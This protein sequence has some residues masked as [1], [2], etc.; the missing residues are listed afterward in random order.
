VDLAGNDLA[1]DPVFLLAADSAAPSDP[2]VSGGSTS[3]QDASSVTV[4]ASGSTDTG[5]SDGVSGYQYETS[6]NGGSTWSSATSGSSTAVTAEG[7]TLVRFRALDNVGNA[8][9]WVTGTVRLDRTAPTAPTVSGGSLS[10]SSAASKT[11][12]GAGSTDAGS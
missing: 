3:W 2:T 4:S 7:E 1:S 10:W 8:S 9:N 11:I 5:C 6:T 12:T